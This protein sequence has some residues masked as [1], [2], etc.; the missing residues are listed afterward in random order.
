MSAKSQ[1]MEVPMK[2]WRMT[3]AERLG[4]SET[5]VDYRLRSGKYP[6]LNVRRVNKR[7]VWVSPK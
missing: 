1:P 4:L 6:N 7:V 3:E 2:Q 5:G